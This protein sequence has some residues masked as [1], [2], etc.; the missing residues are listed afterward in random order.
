MA[1]DQPTDLFGEST[2]LSRLDVTDDEVVKDAAFELQR[3]ADDLQHA[4]WA[5][6]W[7]APLTE[8]LLN[9]TPTDPEEL[10]EARD[11]A[12]DAE[13][14]RDALRAVVSGVVAE[15]DVMATDLPDEVVNRLNDLMAK[16]EGA[17]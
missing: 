2:L 16:L 4:R 15:F 1:F 12:N 3:C 7:G 13:K 6:R 11:A 9:G 10:E 17:L 14:S 5:R 8:A